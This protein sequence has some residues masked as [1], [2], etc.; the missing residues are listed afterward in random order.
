L[1]D[2]VARIN[3]AAGYIKGKSSLKPSIGIILGTGLGELVGEMQIDAGLDYSEIPNF[4]VSTVPTHRGR[5]LLG[6]LAGKNVVVMQGRFHYYEGYTLQQVTFPVRVMKE[7]GIKTLVLTNISGGVNPE[8]EVG[9][10]VIISDHINHM[11]T[12]PLMGPN[13]D[14]LGPRFPDMYDIYDSGLRE[15]A[16]IEAEAND[17]PVRE[18]VYMGMTGPSLETAAEYKMAHLL[19]AD[20]VGMSTVPEAIVARHQGTK[21]LG[22][23]LITD[24]GY[25]SIEPCHK[26]VARF[27]ETNYFSCREDTGIRAMSNRYK[28][29]ESDFKFAEQEAKIT[30]F[31]EQNSIFEKSVQ[32]RAKAP[33]YIFY[34]GPPTANG[35][36]HVGHALARTIKDTICRYKTMKGFLVERKAGWDTHGLPVELEVEKTLGIS[37]KDEIEKLGIEKFNA[38]C[39]KSVFKYKTEW[40]EFTRKLGYWV[41]LSNPYITYQN[42]YIETV[43]WLLK[44]FWSKELLYK[45]HKIL[46]WCPR[47]ETALSSHETAQGYKEITDPSLYVTMKLAGSKDTYFLVWTTTPWT[48]ISNVAVALHPYED[49]VTIRHEGKNLILAKHRLSV[50]DGAYEILETKKGSEYAGTKYEPLFDFLKVEKGH[51]AVTAD[52]VTMDDGSGIVH[53]APAFGADDYDLGMKEGLS[54]VQAVNT[55]GRFIDDVT[56]WAGRFVKDAD[57]E[58][59]KDLKKRGLFFRSDDYT[60][61]YPHCWR[62]DSPLIYYARSSWFIKTT[63][64]KDAMIAANKE[65]AWYPDE[66][67]SRRF[68]EWLENNID[69]ALSRERYWGTPLPVWICEKC[70]KQHCIGS[71]EELREMSTDCPDDLDLHRPYVDSIHLKCQSCG[72]K[73]TRT[74]EVID[75]WFDSGSMPYAQIHY[76][77]ENKEQFEERYFP[78]AFIAEGL[79]QTRGWFYSLLAI[80]VFISGR[81]CYRSCVVNNLVL[82]TEGRKMSKRLGNVLDPSQLL[83]DFG[84]DTVRWYLMSASQIWLPKRFDSEGLV[85][86][87]RRFFSTLQNTY[88]FFALYA[89][90]DDYVPGADDPDVSKR[91]QIDRWFVSRLNSVIAE[92][93]SAYEENDFTRA[94]RAIADFVVDD[95]SNWYVR[96]NRRRFWGSEDAADKKAAYRTLFD[97][98][99]T[100]C[101]LAAP[102]AP[103]ITEDIYRRMTAGIDGYSESIHLDNFPEVRD[104]LRDEALEKEMSIARRTVELGRAARKKSNT[105]VRQPLGRIIVMGLSDTERKMLTNMKHI[106]GEEINVK[107]L[108]FSDDEKSYFSYK[109]DPDF[110]RIGP[111]FGGRSKAVAENIKKLGSPEIDDL[112]KK[113]S[114]RIGENAD[115]AEISVDDVRVSLISCDGYSVAADGYLKIALD[116]KIDDD[117]LAE[118]N[119]RELV[120]KIQNLRKSSGLEVTDRIKL[121]ISSNPESEIAL[122]KFT[123]Y[124]KDETL[125][126]DLTADEDLKFSQEFDLNGVKT[127]VALDRVS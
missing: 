37:T 99:L 114:L 108:T 79:D 30:E 38:E 45:G 21:V 11:G 80:S 111:K 54:V 77:F 62:C 81:S 119:A 23:S 96:R 93:S 57:P 63:E 68:G 46:P 87:A 16:R 15:L 116:L 113:G 56:P 103:F 7:L 10:I 66:V 110:K 33:R 86:I 36:P 8:F 41:D 71:I 31:W 48:L 4:P 107:D 73:M 17:I 84:A 70:G 22:F 105:R 13:H 101:K 32:T 126:L 24:M 89:N 9:D 123:D 102:V 78:A 106:V 50:I 117:L 72:S 27:Q 14:G 52:F 90:I 95:L 85:E 65:I 44:Q 58:I 121:S 122:G 67:G 92:A 53:I 98:L 43:W 25:P 112:L 34:E 94:T 120:N 88:S 42:E 75:A 5:L 47:C 82:D 115:S 29:T 91:P 6:S 125:A 97:S 83:S 3:Q 39:K 55:E 64:F 59:T 104:E 76:P 28:P 61:N 51:Y 127:I 1:T 2:L 19:G 109:A 12:N 100:V 49:Y 69:W 118:G 40:D 74:T 35:L 20:V 60:H 26:E 124:I 18:G